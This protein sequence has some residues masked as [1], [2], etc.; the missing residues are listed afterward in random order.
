MNNIFNH[1]EN[2]FYSGIFLFI[3]ILIVGLG[4]KIFFK[5]IYPLIQ[6][7]LYKNVSMY[8]NRKNRENELKEKLIKEFNIPNSVSIFKDGDGFYL[9]LKR[10]LI[11]GSDKKIRL[12]E[13]PNLTDK[14]KKKLM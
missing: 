3:L 8:R 10:S 12:N 7:F 6:R 13:Y 1:K 2:R 4:V 14:Q 11:Y 9:N 5:F